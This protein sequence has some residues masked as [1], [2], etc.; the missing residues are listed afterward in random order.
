[1]PAVW[2]V[3]SRFSRSHS[4]ESGG[5]GSFSKT[6]RAAPRDFALA[7]GFD[8][9]RLIDERA[10]ADVDQVGIGL[11]FGELWGGRSFFESI[12]SRARRGPRSRS[13]RVVRRGGTTAGLRGRIRA[14]ACSGCWRAAITSMPNAAAWLATAR[15]MLPRP[16]R[17][18]VAPASSRGRWPGA[19]GDFLSP[20]VL[21]LKAHGGGDVLG[22]GKD[23]CDDVL[24]DH[25]AVDVAAV[26][27]DDVAVH[28]FWKQELVYGCGWGVDPAEVSARLETGRGGCGGVRRFRR[29]RFRGRWCRCWR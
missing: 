2:G 16:T 22:Q 5:S 27:E 19:P 10:A 15:P 28:Q 14:S 9:S 1:M 24:G 12:E 7:Q 20:D 13:A 6:S 26:G 21:L 4:G 3:I 17:P 18:R 11:H 29:R 25:R 8:Q 23:Q